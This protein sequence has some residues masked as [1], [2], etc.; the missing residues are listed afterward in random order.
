[1]LLSRLAEPA[2]RLIAVAVG[3]GILVVAQV[4]VLVAGGVKGTTEANRALD[5]SFTYLADVSEERVV[6]YASAATQVANE[7]ARTLEFENPGKSALIGILQGAVTSRAQV[8][9]VSVT[10]PGGAYAEL[11]RSAL[12]SGGYSSHVILIDT[13]G[14]AKH[15][16]GEYDVQM[17]LIE[18]L[19]SDIRWDPREAGCYERATRA[20]SAVWS[21]PEVNPLTGRVR[22][23]VCQAVRTEIGKVTAVVSA[24]IDLS[25]L[26]AALNELP[27][28]SDGDVFLLSS[29]RRVLA[30][31]RDDVAQW[32][33]FATRMGSAPLARMMGAE[34]DHE[35]GF[36]DV[37]DAFGS[38][39]DY[40]V[41]ERGLGSSR[42]EWVIH[43]R[44]TELGVNE[45]FTKLRSTIIAIVV[46]LIGITLGMGYLLFT[47]WGPLKRVR[48][49]AERDS[50]TGLY[51]RHHVEA[52]IARAM[53]SAHRSG[54]P[55]AV[56][57]LDLDNFKSLNDDLGHNAGDAAL[58]D[59]GAALASEIRATDIAVRWGGDE[60]LVVLRLEAPSDAE[61]T[62]E[63]IRARTEEAL[64]A[65][66]RGREGLGV[67]AGYALS[68]ER[69]ANVEELIASA[70]AAL[71]DGKW[72]AKGGTYQA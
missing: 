29:D 22:V 41:L 11:S 16:L 62:V 33:D 31:P 72:V 60:F 63:R 48:D 12:R 70:D 66:Y 69:A 61:A 21:E 24:S 57:M 54:H 71:I 65:R 8:E 6:T 52:R 19:A 64:T 56:I 38:D 30:T 13:G 44:A 26:G 50:L 46:G 14:V 47:M 36:D 37:D 7:T 53:A 18:E 3:V 1:M 23:W 49:V 5:G 59:V 34:T 67:T 20:A 2:T 39:G 55:V 40:R 15:R 51:N 35:V 42:L 58:A 25:Q 27:T 43:L 32:N 45:G 68:T 4:V 28:G 17:R 10:Y 9:A